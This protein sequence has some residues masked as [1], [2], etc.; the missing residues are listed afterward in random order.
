MVNSRA[1]SR[2]HHPLRGRLL[3]ATRIG[4]VKR[5]G[6]SIVK[7][8]L[9]KIAAWYNNSIMS[10]GGHTDDNLPYQGA[11]HT[12]IAHCS[13]KLRP[14]LSAAIPHDTQVN[15]NKYKDELPALNKG[16]LGRNGVILA[17]PV[18]AGF[19]GRADFWVHSAADQIFAILE[20]GDY[21]ERVTQEQGKEGEY[22]WDRNAQPL[23][24]GTIIDALFRVG[25]GAVGIR[26]FPWLLTYKFS[27]RQQRVAL[28]GVLPIIGHGC[29]LVVGTQF[30]N[31]D[32]DVK[33]GYTSNCDIYN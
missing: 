4:L 27:R 23:R 24:P 11:Q 1:K 7:Y 9:A 19:W 18:L 30:G 21:V 29:S 17:A 6:K 10:E 3:E 14:Y 16:K 32:N 26:V 12:K 33:D 2:H 15:G 20:H 5:P 8:L 25:I 31:L 22:T 13:T 28:V